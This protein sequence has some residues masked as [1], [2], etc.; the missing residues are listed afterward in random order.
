VARRLIL[1]KSKPI[2]L[3]IFDC[4]LTL[5]NHE[6]ASELKRPL[7]LAAPDTVRDSD[8]TEVSLFPE[9]R[10]IMAEL[11]RRGYLLSICS[12]NRPEPV[13]EMLDL[14]ALR[15]YMRHPKA[16]PHPDKGAMIAGMLEQFADD[17][18][19]LAPDQVVFIDDRTLHT[20]G[21][22]ALLPGLHVL[23]IWVDIR[24]HNDLLRWLEDV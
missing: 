21:I 4:D 24:D 22:L 9:V 7:V 18:V 19:A 20:A 15:R 6:D 11:E 2:R 12:W 10:S 8:G 5:W 17:G 1:S 14:F 16:E 13:L 3:I 23:Q